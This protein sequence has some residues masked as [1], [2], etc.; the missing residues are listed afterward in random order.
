MMAFRI[1]W[2]KVHKPLAFYSAYFYRRSQKGGF[3]AAMMTGGTDDVRRRINDMRRRTDLTAN[4][5]DLLVT[6]EA[7]YEFNMRGFEFAPIDLYESDATKFMLADEKR[8]RPPFVAI[9]GLGESAAID[10]ARIKESGKRYISVEEL[11]R[12]C[13]KVSQT[14]LEQVKA[15]GALG[16]MPESSQINLFEL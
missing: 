12:D 3:D 9:S 4:Q 2:F 8:L 6:L 14:H 1:A 10:L 7:V 16:D 11:S 13:P 5:E 15:L